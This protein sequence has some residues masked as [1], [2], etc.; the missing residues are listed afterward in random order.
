ML[1]L[2]IALEGGG[3]RCAA[4]AG[5]LAA[6]ADKHVAPDVIA[7]CGCGAWVAALYA[8]GARSEG[9]RSAVR[10][11]KQAGDWMIRRRAAGWRMFVHGRA[12]G[13]GILPMRRIE[14]ALRWQTLDTKLAD[15][16]MPLAIPTWDVESGEEQMLSSRLPEKSSALA[17]NRQ[18]TLAQAVR[19][20]ISAPGFCEPA[21]WRGRT[22]TGGVSHWA[23][24]PDALRDLGADSILRIRVLTLKD[25]CLDPLTMASCS[26]LPRGEDG[27][28]LLNIRLPAG[29]KLLD[30]ANVELYF[31]IGYKAALAARPIVAKPSVKAGGKILPFE[32]SKQV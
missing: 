24:L 4:Q 6:L 13:Q 7:G 10:D 27:D 18:A 12:D 2:G 16:G 20:A 30:C 14:K 17:W 1:M 29:S 8:M 9:L 21:V 32:R 31:D 15:V 23:T 3:A 28:G 26:R 11:I 22:L 19:A 25:A 5:A